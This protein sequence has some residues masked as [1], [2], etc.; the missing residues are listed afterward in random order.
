MS[1][2][3]SMAVYISMAGSRPGISMSMDGSA[4]GLLWLECVSYQCTR[5][6]TESEP[7]KI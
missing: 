6:G 4:A 1:G 3:I 5:Y 7:E 2:Y